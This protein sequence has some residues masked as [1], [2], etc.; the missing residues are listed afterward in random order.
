MLD[1]T[2]SAATVPAENDPMDC[3]EEEYDTGFVINIDVGSPLQL[4]ANEDGFTE[5]TPSVASAAP[6]Q[7]T[8]LSFEAD[9]EMPLY[10]QQSEASD[11]EYISDSDEDAVPHIEND[12]QSRTE[13]FKFKQHAAVNLD[14]HVQKSFELC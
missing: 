6:V 4:A 2:A 7:G 3:E 12:M 13:G 9:D 10:F 8:D 5:A 14:P 11:K 1:N